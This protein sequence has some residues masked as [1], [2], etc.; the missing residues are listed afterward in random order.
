MP[1]SATHRYVHVCIPKT[2]TT[3]VCGAFQKYHKQHGG[4]YTLMKEPVDEAFRTLHGLHAIGDRHPGRA[5]HLSALQLRYVLGDA[6]DQSFRFSFVRNPWARC[7][8]QYHFTRTDHEPSDEEK[9]RR[10]TRR[11]FHNRTFESWLTN[12]HLLWKIS[13]RDRSQLRKIV[14][15][16]GRWIVDFVGRLESVQEGMGTI[17]DRLDIPQLEVP[18]TNPTRHGRY[19]EYYTP[20][21]RQLV[22]EMYARDIEAFGYAFSD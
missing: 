18:W 5:K 13:G 10:G 7:V 9:R 21:L 19:V 11:R 8:S 15:H 12:R 20:K 3:S 22:D 16:D 4:T 1:F 2:G 14:G 17:C 6:F